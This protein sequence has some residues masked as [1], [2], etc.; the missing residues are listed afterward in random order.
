MSGTSYRCPVSNDRE[1][2]YC[3]RRH[4]TGHRIAVPATLPGSAHKQCRLYT[5][6]WSG[7]G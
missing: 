3:V 1:L 4:T 6:G 7:G 2:F 5:T